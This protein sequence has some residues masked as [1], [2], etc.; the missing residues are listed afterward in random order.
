MTPS[1]TLA[2]LIEIVK[3]DA[4]R[5]D[6]L[7]QLAQASR[8]VS[9]LEQVSDELLGHFVDQCRRGG[10]SWSEISAALGVSKQAAHK[11]FSFGAPAFERFTE[12]ARAVLSPGAEEQARLLG[13]GFVGTEHLLLALFEPAESMA[14]RILSDLGVTRAGAEEKIL[15]MI[16]RG[17]APHDGPRPFT[18]R[19]VG[20][21]SGA[22][23]E[24]L[25]LGHNYVGTEHLLLGLFRDP[26]GLA[27]KALEQLGVDRDEVKTR[28]VTML[29]GYTKS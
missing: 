4:A 26:E 19:A 6:T 12:R 10:H 3:A 9:D 15:G 8:T 18:P 2:E 22:A 20:V 11:R 25:E 23:V 29:S 17:S 7:G 14:A 1:P 13:H 24:A 21:L 28:V 27:A 5:D 16:H